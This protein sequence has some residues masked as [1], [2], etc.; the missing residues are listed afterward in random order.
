MKRGRRVVRVPVVPP[1]R[2]HADLVDP[3]AFDRF[4]R[5]VV[6][7]SR[8]D[9]MIEAKAKDLALLQLR[10]ELATSAQSGAHARAR[11]PVVRGVSVAG[12]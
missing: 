5:E 6:G 9:V 2:A 1:R 8:V 4:M 11:P 10:E 3:F 12:A 7:S